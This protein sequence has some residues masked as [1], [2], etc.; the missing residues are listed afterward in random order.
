[1]RG[2]E[3][4]RRPS[5]RHRRAASAA[6]RRIWSTPPCATRARLCRASSPKRR[7][8][9]KLIAALGEAFG[10]D[11]PIRR[12]EIYDNSHIMGTNAIGAM[13]VA[14]PEGFVK[15]QYR[16]FNIKSADLTP[17][18]RLRDDARG[19]D[20]PLRPA[21]AA[22]RD[23]GGRRLSRHARPRHHR[24][25]AA[26]SS[27]RRARSSARLASR[28]CRL[29]AIAKGP[30]RN[31]GRETFFVEGREPF[32]LTP[33]RS[34]A[35]LHPAPARRGAPLRHRDPPR[36]AQE[37]IREKP[38]RRNPRHRPGAQAGAPVRLRLGQGRRQSRPI[39]PRKDARPQRRDG[40]AGLRLLPR[41][42]GAPG[43]AA[44]SSGP[45]GHL[46]PVGEG[47]HFEGPPQWRL[48]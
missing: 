39:R 47:I 45:S 8:Q 22:G 11:R 19:A 2:L 10:V 24:R 25:R 15:N 5:H 14:G 3:R 16:T 33:A 36:A 13:V 12:V 41:E 27:R 17:G 32:R 20:A 30:D 4:P 43:E 1:M 34:G 42:P 40:E 37:G 31:A 23:G 35:V 29:V 44:P 48:A 28:A 21:Q 38:A 6:R 26:G 9:E 7:R 46:L 18:R